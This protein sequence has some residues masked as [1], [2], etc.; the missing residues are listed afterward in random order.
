MLSISKTGLPA[1]VLALSLVLGAGEGAADP[2]GFCP[3]G[4]AKKGACGHHE[5]YKHKE[6]RRYY[7]DDDDDRYYRY[8][9][10]GD[11][12]IEYRVIDYRRYD[13]RR[14]RYGEVYV[15]TGGRVYLL[16]EATQRVIEAINLFNAATN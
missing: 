3:P 16:A 11:R 5:H 12:I 2:K 6:K 10:R 14:P 13:L 1:A 7:E 9:E 15:E 8:Y 4:L